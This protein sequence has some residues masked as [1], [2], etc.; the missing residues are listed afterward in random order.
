MGNKNIFERFIE[1]HYG[2]WW[3]GMFVTLFYVSEVSILI[4]CI[5]LD[6]YL[7]TNWFL[8]GSFFLFNLQM[9][10]YFKEFLKEKQEDGRRIS[11]FNMDRTYNSVGFTFYNVLS[12]ISKSEG[13]VKEAKQSFLQKEIIAIAI[14]VL[15]NLIL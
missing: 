7:E 10:L 8:I 1:S 14:L 6:R 2:S 9:S 5:K 15:I 13:E 3:Y 4:D 12:G 11:D